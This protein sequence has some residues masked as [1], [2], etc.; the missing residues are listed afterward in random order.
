MASRA[1]LE[2]RARVLNIVAANY[3]ND[4][5]LEQAVLYKEKTLAAASGTATYL[6]IPATAYQQSGD[7]NV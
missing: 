3:P 7:A 2:L 6:A 4:S 5:T 1:S